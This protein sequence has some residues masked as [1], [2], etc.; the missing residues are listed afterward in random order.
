MSHTVHH[1]CI[2]IDNT[3]A[4]TDK[5]MR[6]VI[7]EV[8]EGRVQLEYDDVV[9]FNY[10]EC[11]DSKG[12]RITKDEWKVVH[13]R[14]SDESYLL[15]VEPLPKAVDTIH[16]LAEHGV[17]H[18]ATSRL[19]KARK[20]TIEWL[21][22]HGL[23]SHDL[24]FLRHG[25][26][27]AALKRFTAAIEDDYDQAAAFAY[28]GKTPCFLIRHPWNKSRYHL[29]NVQW[30]SDWAELMPALLEMISSPELGVSPR[31]AAQ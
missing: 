11:R 12:N 3:I 28:V 16:A 9:T 6:R 23:L 18:L 20:T 7:A 21:A 10:Y 26:K 8:T 1:F 2:D 4:Q 17:V 30:A 22:I 13:N 25:E 15:S 19:P 24:H 27:H 5:V 31:P 29:P 14:F